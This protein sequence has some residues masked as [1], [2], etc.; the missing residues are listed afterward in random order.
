MKCV[1][2]CF[3]L[4][5]QDFRKLIAIAAAA[6]ALLAAVLFVER[7]PSSAAAVPTRFSGPTSS[8]PLALTA[9]DAFLVV[10][11]TDNNTVSFFDL[12]SNRNRKL[13]EVPV[14]GE[15]NG[16]AFLPDGT[17]AFV[18]NTLS[19]TVS[20]IKTNIRNGVISKTLVNIK[21]GTEPYGLALTPN[22]R[23]LYVSNSR[24]DS[25][26]IIDTATNTVIKTIANVGAEPRG[27]AVTNDGDG[28]DNDE[29]VY[30]T[31]FLS[32]PIAGKLD[33]TD[34]SKEGRVT[35]LST[36]TDT[37]VG[38]VKINPLANTGFNA[39]GDAIA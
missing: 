33:G 37:I 39:T 38:V 8:Q 22:G 30:V 13:A 15:P 3:G 10:S 6:V 21:V 1:Q 2:S 16:V 14:Q 11:N 5:P 23:K 36:A 17:K 32:L 20:V 12:R 26:S 25:I 35:V 34:D 27:L 31:Q 9:D 4:G 7:N 28:D 24:S 19:G 18:A 29:T